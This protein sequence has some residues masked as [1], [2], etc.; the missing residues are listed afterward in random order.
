MFLSHQVDHLL[1]GTLMTIR[2]HR[3]FT[4]IELL[5]VI[6]IIA[7][8]IA[9]LLPAVQQARE[10]ARRTQCRNN[11][12]QLGLAFHNYES[13]YRQIPSCYVAI[14]NSILPGWLGVAG[15]YDDAN[16]H[17]YA[18]YLLPYI[19]QTNIYNQITF[20]APYLSPIDLSAAGLGNYTADNKT[21]IANVVP[22]Y[23][24]PSTPRASNLIDITNNDL[25]I[26]LNWRTGAMDYSPSAGM[27]GAQCL[28]I[29]DE[30]NPGWFDGAMSNNRP[31][32]R[33][34]NLSDGSTNVMLMHELAGRNDLYRVG[35]L[36]TPN[37]TIGG[38]W[39]DV[40]N[41]E[42]WLS[43]S[44]YDGVAQEVP[45]FVNCTN[46]GGTGMYSFHV[47]MANILLGDG[48]V[49]GLGA[50]VSREIV[51]KL[52]STSGGGVLGEF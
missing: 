28:G 13:T 21:A 44:T 6:A 10:A 40:S 14:H 23:I 25:G 17:T 2:R 35:V 29:P 1:K 12:K 7:I 32:T 37:G 27:W 47:G 9:L 16:I 11:M 43:G 42:N 50:N 24:C 48:S 18:E 49:R 22:P 26:P 5:V 20:T 38:G 46:A 34:A 19:D 3:G 52:V 41:A 36:V 51:V 39:A 8:L 45:C 33:L 4:L 30:P 15:P 31:N